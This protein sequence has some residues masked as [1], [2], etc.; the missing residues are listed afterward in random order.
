MQVGVHLPNQE[1][2]V[3]PAATSRISVLTRNP[4]GRE[5]SRSAWGK[6]DT[7]KDLGYKQP[8]RRISR[9]HEPHLGAFLLRTEFNKQE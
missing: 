9:L 5:F 2:I 1:H 3:M 7:Y 8:L 6:S 4:T